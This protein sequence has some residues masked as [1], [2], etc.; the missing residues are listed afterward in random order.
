MAQ[1]PPGSRMTRPP[2][3][4]CGTRGQN[5]IVWTGPHPFERAVAPLLVSTLSCS[6]TARGSRCVTDLGAQ[7]NDIYF[8]TVEDSRTRAQAGFNAWGADYPAAAN[9]FTPLFT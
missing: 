8:C 7:G 2:A 3:R 9:F 4:G 5:V 6:D 1:P